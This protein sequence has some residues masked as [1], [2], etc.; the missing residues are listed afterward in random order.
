MQRSGVSAVGQVLMAA[1]LNRGSAGSD[2]EPTNDDPAPFARRADVVAFNDALLRSFGW[3]WDSIPDRAPPE[4]PDRRGLVTRGRDL[5]NSELTGP[6]AWFFADPRLCLV[7][8][9]WRRILQDRF[10]TVV[11]WRP[12]EEVAWSL[13]LR[14]QLPLALCFVL[15]AAYHRHLAAGLRGLPVIAVDYAALTERPGDVV[16]ALLAALRAAGV[17]GEFD[18]A[19]GVDA[20]DLSLRRA[21]QPRDLTLDVFISRETLA[22]MAGWPKGEVQLIRRFNHKPNDPAAWESSMLEM[23]RRLRT[24]LHD[25]AMVQRELAELKAKFDR[26]GRAAAERSSIAVSG[27]ADPDRAA[28]ETDDPAEQPVP[29]HR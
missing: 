1:G 22:L 4:T 7:L 14:E 27:D 18:E 9:V 16:P 20:V 17:R 23:Q 8:P 28:A 11:P 6:E 5:V 25:R 15:A 2:V 21:T 29:V 10:V 26:L 19:R 12:M 24:V 3:A 13:H